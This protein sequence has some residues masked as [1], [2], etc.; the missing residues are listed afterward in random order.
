[1]TARSITLRNSR[2]TND[3]YTILLVTKKSTEPFYRDKTGWLMVSARG[4]NFRNTAEQILNHLLPVL[5]GI[6]PSLII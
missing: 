4:R 5:A 1:M 2:I 3:R 6:K